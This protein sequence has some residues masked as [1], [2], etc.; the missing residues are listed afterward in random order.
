MVGARK[1]SNLFSSTEDVGVILLE[2]SH[3]GEPREGSREL[4]PV[5]H[6]K[7]SHPQRELTPRAGTMVIHQT[8]QEGRDSLK[9]LVLFLREKGEVRLHELA[10]FSGI[11]LGMSLLFQTCPQ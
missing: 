9:N 1:V 10:T 11:S 4:I 5:Q 7:V 2:P 3:P 6:A 8:G